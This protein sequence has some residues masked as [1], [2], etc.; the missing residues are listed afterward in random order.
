MQ[1]DKEK[2]LH[3][4]K[5]VGE[6]IKEIRKN[7]TG[8]SINKLALEYDLD[9]GNL[10]RIENGKIDTQFSTIW[11]IS[12]ALNISFSEFASILENKLGKDFKFIDE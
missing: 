8:L 11:K 2:H 5:V 4:N 12:E 7:E 10:S 3:F 9:R 1:Q 6:T